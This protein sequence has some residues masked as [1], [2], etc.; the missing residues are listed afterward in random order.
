MQKQSPI[1]IPLSTR[2]KAWWEGYDVND[3]EARLRAS[4]GRSNPA[5]G[6]P[7]P[8]QHGSPTRE[9]PV[10]PWSTSRIHIS[11]YI[12]GEG[13][14]G[15]GGPDHIIGM[16]KL[17]AL[18]PEMSMMVLGAGLGGPARVLAHEFGV[19]ITGY[20][21]SEELATAGMDLS[22]MHGMAKKAPILH[23]NPETPEPFERN[24]D[25][26]FIKDTLFTI[27]NKPDLMRK[28]NS[29]LKVDSLVLVS[30][31]VMRSATFRD[32]PEYTDWK[33]QEPLT[34]YLATH[35]EELEIFESAGFA[36]RVNED[37]SEHY[38]ELITR[39]WA[40]VD[41]VVNDLMKQGEQ[42]KGMIET[43]LHEAEFWSLR[44]KLLESGDL[45][46]CRILA[47]KKADKSHSIR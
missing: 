1:K 34:P 21:T 31:Y 17:L 35:D 14:C 43:L 27:A 30:D 16:S 15:P 29:K 46:M 37:I 42:G 12:W 32:K 25:R 45:Q 6:A 44:A 18:S 19:W 7:V 4:N 47:S 41:T 36:V 10:L 39:A 33:T 3:I 5:G 38:V 26:A 9:L 28:V 23:Y 13:H 2:L 20:E 11:Q 22:T 8:P 40:H 24:F